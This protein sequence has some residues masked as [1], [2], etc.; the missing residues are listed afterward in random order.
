MDTG[1]GIFTR[2]RFK[3]GNAPMGVAHSHA[4]L[5]YNEKLIQFISMGCQDALYCRNLGVQGA[6]RIETKEDNADVGQPAPEYE[7]AKVAIIRN[8]YASFSTC[9]RQY[10]IVG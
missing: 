1:I 2:S 10:D 5:G 9:Q 7:F 4:L 8:Q 3:R 6:I